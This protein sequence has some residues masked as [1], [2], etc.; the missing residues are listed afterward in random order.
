MPRNWGRNKIITGYQFC[1]VIQKVEYPPWKERED[2]PVQ[3]VCGRVL[4][5]LHLSAPARGEVS[6]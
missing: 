4:A 6:C 1:G 5:R 2:G 3:L